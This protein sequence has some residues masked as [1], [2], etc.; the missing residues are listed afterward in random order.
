MK[1]LSVKQPFAGLISHGDEAGYKTLEIRS[2]QTH[3]R[4]PVLICASQKIHQGYVIVPGTDW[5]QRA[6]NYWRR[7]ILHG[8][9][10]SLGHAHCVADLIDCRP[11]QRED[12]A[13]ACCR[14]YPDLYAWHLVNVRLIESF[15]VKGA[16][17][18]F[19]VE[20]HKIKYLEHHAH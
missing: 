17:G 12:E 15:P 4:G 1:A 3:Y 2:W 9:N 18:L 7:H 6:E 13:A 10:D 11:M 5:E 20:D 14:W 19:D 16:L 8:Y